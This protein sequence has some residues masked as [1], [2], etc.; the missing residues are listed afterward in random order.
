MSEY[1][2][3]FKDGLR[4][5]YT[6]MLSSV[7]AAM[8]L[9]DPDIGSVAWI[10]ERPEVAEKIADLYREHTEVEPDPA[11]PLARQLADLAR[12]IG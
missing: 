3:G 9:D 1:D 6:K 12:M 11:A 5:A 2:R 7:V 10:I 4:T 8:G